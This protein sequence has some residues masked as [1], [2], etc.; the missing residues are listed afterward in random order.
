MGA[1][2]QMLIE[3]LK[4][5]RN[6]F[7]NVTQD[8]KVPE[9]SPLAQ[10]EMRIDLDPQ[11]SSI[12][13][14]S[15]S[16][17]SVLYNAPV[18]EKPSSVGITY[19]AG[20]KPAP[21]TTVSPYPTTAAQTIAQTTQQ[22]TQQSA[23]QP[24]LNASQKRVQELEQMAVQNP[25]LTRNTGYQTQLYAAR[26]DAM[27]PAPIQ[28]QPTPAAKTIAQ[29]QYDGPRLG[30]AGDKLNDTDNVGYAK[31]QDMLYAYNQIHDANY[32]Q[33]NPNYS[34]AAKYIVD[35]HRNNGVLDVDKF[36]QNVGSAREDLRTRYAGKVTPQAQ[37][38]A[39]YTPNTLDQSEKAVAQTQWPAWTGVKGND[40]TNPYRRI[41]SKR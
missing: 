18:E 16:A 5:G 21:S 25:D 6:P 13:S 23:P 14:E 27:K 8:S 33:D 29:P 39:T 2:I 41:S 15:P 36:K 32:A 38:Q 24:R 30:I 34:P 1:L 4:N 7:A 26:A 37:G 22:P 31:P 19:N 35:Q 17:P 20:Q 11:R 12:V 28:T 40:A 9:A 10:S 3:F